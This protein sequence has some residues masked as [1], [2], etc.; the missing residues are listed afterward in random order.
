MRA[1]AD[2]L[3]HWIAAGGPVLIILGLLSLYSLALVAYKV[4][5]F[6]GS[7][8]GRALRERAI[9]AFRSGAVPD[10]LKLLGPG[11]GAVNRVVAATMRGLAERRD[12]TA[13][14]EEVE[15]WAAVELERLG[16]HLRTLE[17]IGVVSPLLGLLGTVLG[18]I[19]SFQQLEAAGGGA[20]A[21]VLAAG[22]WEALLTTAMGLIVAI[23]AA[24][25]AS[26]L[27]ARLERVTHTIEDGVTRL[28][29]ASG[30][31]G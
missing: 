21:S 11:G 20:N 26:L 16:R 17:V 7:M 2:V 29:T 25:A 30:R 6:Q 31:A 23:P 19:E 12:S 28:V 22:I 8:G 4:A 5:Q 15:G 10:A 9:S 1:M 3:S 14:R 13:L 27:G 24:A 18:M